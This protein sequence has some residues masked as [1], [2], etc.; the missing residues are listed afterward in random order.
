MADVLEVRDPDR[1]AAIA[2]LAAR[3]F[4]LACPPGTR[5]LDVDLFVAEHL[6][7]VA[8]AGYVLDPGTTVT[9]AEE[10]ERPVGYSLLVHDHEPGGPERE[11]LRH[12][13]TS[14]LSKFYLDPDRHGG[15]IAS[16][17]MVQ[18]VAAAERAGS[19]G[20]WLGVNDQNARAIRFY[21][22]MGFETVGTRS[23]TLGRDTHSD[24]VL[25]RELAAG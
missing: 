11:S 18:T 14:L 22:R 5:R 4:P 9:V 2:A 20:V 10:A 19:A 17:L 24:L 8:F 7:P 23:F 12:H 13:P 25:E 15:G 21:T 16:A 6:S 3:T 1:A